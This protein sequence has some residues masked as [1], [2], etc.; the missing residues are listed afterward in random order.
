MNMDIKIVFLLVFGGIIGL[1]VAYLL[2]I[3][4]GSRAKKKSEQLFG[5]HYAHRGL[6]SRDQ[7]VPENSLAAFRGAADAGY[8]FELDLTLTADHHVVV[9]HDN[10][11]DRIC[12][13]EG[14]VESLTLKEL[15]S[16]KLFGTEEGIPLFHEVLRMTDGKVPMIIELKHANNYEE[17]C[18]KTVE[19]LE[20]YTGLYCIESF[21]PRI[22]RWFAVNQP[23]VVRG[24]LLSGEKSRHGQ[25]SILA[26]VAFTLISNAYNRPHFIAYKHQ[27]SHRNLALRLYRMLGGKLVAWTVSD[28]NDLPYCLKTFHTLIFE[29]ISLTEDKAIN[30]QNAQ[31]KRNTLG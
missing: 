2:I 15:S 13:V 20:H 11:L 7:Q 23:D 1:F 19:C 4:P 25:V 26:R 28:S 16:L 3:E 22:V 21:D 29:H 24:Q 14:T 30:G 27:N 17:L 31:S 12:H 9:F 5:R 6:Y 8:G 10:R 18:R